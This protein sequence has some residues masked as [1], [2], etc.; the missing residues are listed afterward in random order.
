MRTMTDREALAHHGEQAEQ[1]GRCAV[2]GRPIKTVP[3]YAFRVDDETGQFH[4]VDDLAVCI[5]CPNVMHGPAI[6]AARSTPPIV[7]QDQSK[8]LA[9]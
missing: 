9:R 2:C 4:Q 8:E 6:E 5:N 1:A 3:Q 7:K